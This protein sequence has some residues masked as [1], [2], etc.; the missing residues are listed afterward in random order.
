[1]IETAPPAQEFGVEDE[2]ILEADA[3]TS[4][5]PD[6]GS[7]VTVLKPV[8]VGGPVPIVA[9]KHNTIQLQP[10]VVPLAVVPY[11]TQDSSVLRTDGRTAQPSYAQEGGEATDFRSYDAVDRENAKKKKNVGAMARIFSLITFLL[12]A[13]ATIP[14]I[15]CYEGVT[16]GKV[17]F[18][19]FDTILLIDMWVNKVIDFSFTPVSNILGIAIM[20]TTM[21]TALFALI[22]I[23]IGK[24]PKPLAC[25]FLF[26][27]L[28]CLVAE[29]VIDLVG[30]NFVFN[31]RI[32]FIVV[33]A[34]TVVAFILSIVFSALINR[35]EDKAEQ[36]DSEI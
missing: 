1:M 27:A 11:M 18:F 26:I 13:I 25:I 4:P 31:D 12:A 24:Y 5:Q 9:P 2:I 29:L 33:L 7:D 34:L 6:S 10:I 8:G 28:G 20:A 21:L 15:L 32:I 16:I 19:E 22:G 3:Y 17:D 23:I 30:K 35:R 36:E 14:Y